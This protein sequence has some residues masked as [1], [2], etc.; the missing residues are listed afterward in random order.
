MTL[1]FSRPFW[2]LF[3]H[4]FG[5]MTTFGVILTAVVLSV[6]AWRRPDAVFLRRATFTT[7]LVSIPCFVVL[8][9]FAQVILDDEDFA[10]DPAWV[11]FGFLA[12]D[13]GLLVLLASIGCAWWW[14]RSGKP[15]AGRIVAALSSIYLLLLT[16][17]MLA[18]SGKWG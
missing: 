14:V 9:V 6:V 7:L 18:M 2:P 17:A 13:A 5:A 12:T 1:A 4:I 16:I 3:L 15:V 11:G 10:K 8:R